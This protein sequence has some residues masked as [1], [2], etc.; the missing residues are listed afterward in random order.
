DEQ[1]LGHHVLLGDQQR[2]AQR[3][4]QP[5]QQAG[6]AA[7][8]AHPQ[9]GDEQAGQD[10]EQVLRQRQR[11]QILADPGDDQRDEQ[12]IERRPPDVQIEPDL[13][14]ELV[15]GPEVV[16]AVAD[17]EDRRPEK[18]RQPQRQRDQPDEGEDEPDGRGGQAPGR[19]SLHGAGVYTT[20]PPVRPTP[21][22][23]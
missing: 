15:A 2:A 3:D 17:D 16:L 18:E 10:T 9:R 5:G 23:G 13:T 8:E 11:G 22:S 6:P 12:G 1:R 21:P 14:G 4:Q 7:P 20:L 19:A